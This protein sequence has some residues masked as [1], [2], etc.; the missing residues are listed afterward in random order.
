[1]IRYI[2]KVPKTK[3]RGV[4]LVRID[5]NT[6]D[7]WRL[8]SVLPTLTLLLG[9]SEKVVLMSHRGRPKGFEAALSLKKD[10]GRIEK[11]LHRRVMSRPC[12]SAP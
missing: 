12:R 5:L 3:L 4:A 2:R 8:E 1:M 7:D 11:L 6:A 10:A 9:T